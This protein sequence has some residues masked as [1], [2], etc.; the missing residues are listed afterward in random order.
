[1][2]AP[3]S[4]LVVDDHVLVSRMLRDRLEME[5]D[6]K[7][8]GVVG[9]ADD[10][11]REALEHKPDVVLM[12]IDMPGLLCFDAARTIGAR[13]PNT[14]ILFL[15]AFFHDRYI[16]QALEV[17]ACGYI[18]KGEPPDT[19]VTAIRSAISGAA[20]FSPE[21]QSRIVIDERGAKLRDSGRSRL[22]TLTPR[23]IEVL[24]Y[25][26]RGMPNKEIG[27]TMHISVKTVDRHVVNLMAK[28]DIHS[29]VE[30]TR[31]A[32]R[33]GLAEA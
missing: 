3:I 23:E 19:V 16:D 6:M 32:I 18:T 28:L 14:C 24:R 27:Q 4:I 21:V 8:V 26:A 7:V 11:V 20:Y 31:M 29:R 9:N 22:S 5:P 1:M 25:V 15:S 30:L 12:D 10:A 2:N 33:E 17:G 13:C